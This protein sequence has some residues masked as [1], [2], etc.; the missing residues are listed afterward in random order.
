M[1]G[2]HGRGRSHE[3]ELAAKSIEVQSP[4]DGVRSELQA[5]GETITRGLPRGGWP[6]PAR[7]VNKSGKDMVG[8]AVTALPFF[9]LLMAAVALVVIFPIL[10]TWL[11]AQIKGYY[12][13]NSASTPAPTG[14]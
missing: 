6:R 5:V 7:K 2:Q 8:I 11:P 3:E 12:T 9:F 1:S 14:M 13:W 4:T 10:V